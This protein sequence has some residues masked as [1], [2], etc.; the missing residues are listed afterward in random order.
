MLFVIHG[1]PFLLPKESSSC[2]RMRFNVYFVGIQIFTFQECNAC[3]APKPGG[4]GGG[5]GPMRGGPP[6]GGR[7]GMGGGGGDRHRPY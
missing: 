1:S 2:S 5:G 7:G 6:G 3:H 4:G